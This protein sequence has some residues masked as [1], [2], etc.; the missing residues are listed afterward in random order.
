M[1]AV[2]TTVAY[3]TVATTTAWEGTC[4]IVIV[5]AVG[6]VVT[7]FPFHLLLGGLWMGASRKGFLQLDVL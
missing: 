6:S 2:A 3:Q 5:G 7:Q 4:Q 1:E